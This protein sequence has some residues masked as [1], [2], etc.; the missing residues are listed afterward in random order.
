MPNREQFL[1]LKNQI[2]R[3]HVISADKLT[4]ITFCKILARWVRPRRVDGFRLLVTYGLK[5]IGS[6]PMR[7]LRVCLERDRPQQPRALTISEH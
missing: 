2:V 1:A 4:A 5:C 6:F 7:P 3:R